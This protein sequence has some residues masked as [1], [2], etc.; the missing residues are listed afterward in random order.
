MK[1][2]TQVAISQPSNGIAGRAACWGMLIAIVSRDVWLSS[3]RIASSSPPQQRAL[4]LEHTLP[5][6][7]GVKTIVASATANSTLWRRR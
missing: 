4:P 2:E 6:W 3:A 5:K 1:R 7:R